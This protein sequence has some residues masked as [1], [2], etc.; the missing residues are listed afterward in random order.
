MECNWNCQLNSLSDPDGGGNLDLVVGLWNAGLA[1][2]VD[3]DGDLDLVVTA[4]STA[5][6]Y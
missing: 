6:L 5:R 4:G 1:A 3:G 2:V